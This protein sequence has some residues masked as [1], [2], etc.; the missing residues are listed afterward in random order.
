MSQWWTLSC[1]ECSSIKRYETFHTVPALE[2]VDKTCQTVLIVAHVSNLRS[3]PL[4]TWSLMSHQ[5]VQ[6]SLN[7][8]KWENEDRSRYEFQLNAVVIFNGVAS[9]TKLTLWCCCCIQSYVTLSNSVIAFLKLAPILGKKGG[10]GGRPRC[11]EVEKRPFLVKAVAERVF[12]DCVQ[13]NTL[14][15]LSKTTYKWGRIQS[16]QRDEHLKV[17]KSDRIWTHNLLVSSARP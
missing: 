13:R 7:L 4:S 16:M 17:K 12:R 6:V 5:K 14:L 3:V 15:L 1:P 10:G 2:L 8:Q 9:V 11:F